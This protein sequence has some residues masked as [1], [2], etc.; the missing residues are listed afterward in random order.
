MTDP[1]VAR[2]PELRGHTRNAL[3]HNA[4][5]EA[6]QSFLWSGIRKLYRAVWRVRRAVWL[7]GYDR[8]RVETVGGA[9]LVVLPGV[10]NGVLLRTGAFMAQT[11][12][13]VPVAADAQA[14][15]LGTG[16]GIGA[17]FAARRAARVVATDINPEAARCA[18]INALAH[19][20]ERKIETRV[21]DLFEPVGDERFDLILFNPPYYRGQPRSMADHAWRSPDAFDRFLRE[22]PEHLTDGGRALVVLST[23]GDI[24]GDLSSP[25]TAEYLTARPIRQ[26]ELINER[27]TIYEITVISEGE[28]QAT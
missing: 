13:S 1:R 19:H 14:L 2:T 25:T 6:A 20:L 4:R 23:D 22:L 12:E 15:D 28:R 8:L 9:R 17:I 24:M 5:V 16:T 11:L 21:G 27:L 3:T 7:R 26:R 18:Q 10:F